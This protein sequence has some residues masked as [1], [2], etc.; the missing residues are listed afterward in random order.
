[1]GFLAGAALAI[2]PGLIL[3]HFVWSRDRLREPLGNLA[4]YLALGAA[5]VFAA[6]GVEMLLSGPILGGRPAGQ[7]WLRTAVWAFLGVALVEEAGKYALLRWRAAHDRHLD[8]PF[9][10]VVYAVAVALGFATVENVF[11]VADGGVHVGVARAL[12]AVPAHALDGTLMGWRLAR[13]ARLAGAAARRERALALVE[14]A[15]WHG[16]YD[17][18]LMLASESDV[19]LSG[20]LIFLWI[21]LVLAQWTVCAQRVARLCRDQHVPR[22]P[23]LIPIQLAERLRG[24]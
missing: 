19:D 2:G 8:E 20:Q 18:L 15:L 14:P 13:A 17:V 5:S 4:I 23:L 12:T 1:L 3:A 22:P 24:R 6:A 21:A 7:E 16:A 10:W 11:Y 9:D